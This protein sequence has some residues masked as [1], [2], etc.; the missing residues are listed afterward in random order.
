MASEYQRFGGLCAIG[1][2]VA[3]FLYA[4][5]FV[6]LDDDLLSGLFLLLSGLLTVAALTAAYERVCDA[7]PGFGLLAL[8]LGALGGAGAAI[9]GGFDLAH[10]INPEDPVPD[11][12]N[13]VDPRGLLTFGF[14]GLALLAIA[15]LGRRGN[16]LPARLGLVGYAFAVL[17]VILYLARLIILDADHPVVVVPALLAGFLFGPAWW[18]WL[19]IELRRGYGAAATVRA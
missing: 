5:A 9:H 17:L 3:G 2:A 12:P 11:L 6:V 19:G 16:T 14:T 18:L 15:W 1:V 7:E 8:V 4:I 13:A 10:E